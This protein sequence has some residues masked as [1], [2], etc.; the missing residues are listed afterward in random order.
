MNKN[1]IQKLMIESLNKA[2]NSDPSAVQLLLKNRVSCNQVLADDS[3]IKVNENGSG[4]DFGALGF[5]NGALAAANI[6][7]IAAKWSE[8]DELIGFCEYIPPTMP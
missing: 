4:F 3:D 5:L 1:E 6:P 7:I 2:Y 8:N